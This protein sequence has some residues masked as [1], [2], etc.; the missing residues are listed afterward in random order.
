MLT[1][2]NCTGVRGVRIKAR[3]TNASGSL[4]RDRFLVNLPGD[5]GELVGLPAGNIRLADN[6]PVRRRYGLT[7]P[8]RAC[9]VQQARVIIRQLLTLKMEIT[10][11]DKRAVLPNKTER[12]TYTKSLTI[13]RPT[14]S[15]YTKYFN[16]PDTNALR[17]GDVAVLYDD[18]VTVDKNGNA[19]FFAK[20]RLVIQNPLELVKEFNVIL[21][22][23]A[24]GQTKTIVNRVPKNSTGYLGIKYT[25]TNST[26]RIEQ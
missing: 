3:I 18:S 14:G 20:A 26:R 24:P 17:A 2:N 7:P 4:G 12:R 22:R 6:N 10:L 25:L 11:T 16:R 8:P 15:P 23:V 21:P 9:Q 13:N 1:W 19:S 5:S